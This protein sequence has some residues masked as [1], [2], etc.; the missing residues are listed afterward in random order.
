MKEESYFLHLLQRVFF[1]VCVHARTFHVKNALRQLNRK[2]VGK[3]EGHLELFSYFYV[4]FT[5]KLHKQSKRW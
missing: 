2:R 4:L 5:W 3:I 1:L